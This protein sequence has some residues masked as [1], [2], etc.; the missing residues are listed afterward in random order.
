MLGIHAHQLQ[1]RIHAT[2]IAYLPL[3]TTPNRKHTTESIY[4]CGKI[5]GIFA[6]MGLSLSEFQNLIRGAI[7]DR[8]VATL[9][10]DA[11]LPRDAI[12]NVLEGHEPK[13]CRAVEICLAVG[14]EFYVGQPQERKPATVHNLTRNGLETSNGPIAIDDPHLANMIAVLA[15]AW[16]SADLLEQGH[17]L[18]RFDLAFKEEREKAASRPGPRVARLASG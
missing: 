14:L 3:S 8:R 17:I 5:R 9:A 7:G 12:R 15:D 16:D 1:R 2:K 18:G 10:V 6:I 4:L 13:L 11:G